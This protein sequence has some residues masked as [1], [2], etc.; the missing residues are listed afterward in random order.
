MKIVK[1]DLFDYKMRYIWQLEDGFKFSLDSLLLAEYVKLS[2]NKKILDMCTGNAPIPLVI[3]LKTNSEIVGFEI[4]EDIA[5]LAKMSVQENKLESQIRIIND[6]INNIGEYYQEEYFD[7]ITCNPPY[8]KKNSSLI[9]MSDYKSIARH[10]VKIDLENIF[11]LSYK[12]LKSNGTLY[13][14]HRPERLDEIIILANKYKINVKE[15]A[16]I[17]TNKTMIPS[18]VLVKCVKLSNLGIKFRKIIDVSK[19]ST[20]QHIFE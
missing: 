6:D 8:F 16:L 1:N 17:V 11:K 2:N 13:M 12:Y 3:S 4:Q 10:E 9:N 5:N 15:A 14:V 19:C 18:L 7:I 20:Y